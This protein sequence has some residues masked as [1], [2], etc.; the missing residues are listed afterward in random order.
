MEP[1]IFVN[2]Q[3]SRRGVGLRPR[4]TRAGKRLQF[5]PFEHVLLLYFYYIGFKDFNYTI[6]LL[7]LLLHYRRDDGLDFRQLL[8]KHRPRSTLPSIDRRQSG[9]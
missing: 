1:L 2:S 5:A 3:I 7:L 6:M 4:R 8:R 9:S